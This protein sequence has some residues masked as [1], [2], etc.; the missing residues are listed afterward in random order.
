MAFGSGQGKLESSKGHPTTVLVVD[1]HPVVREGL[2]ALISHRDIRVIGEAATGRQAV[3]EARRL[4]PDVVLMD[5]R[6]PDMDGLTATEQ[7]KKELPRTTVIIVTSYDD[8]QYIQRALLAGASGYLLK[9]MPREAYIEAIRVV[10]AGASIF[11]AS[12]VP[13]LMAA[14]AATPDPV[15]QQMVAS[16]SEREREVL[17][18][19]AQGLTNK[20]IAERIHYSVGTVKNLVATIIEKL[21]V[22]DRTQ[23]AVVAARAGLLSVDRET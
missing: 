4:R 11:H 14:V 1:D 2:K 16:L 9:G 13:Q 20:E 23:A 17:A 15:A 18:L 3:E 21:N 12:V 19:L 5:I 10:R 7:I 6:L 22:S 8:P